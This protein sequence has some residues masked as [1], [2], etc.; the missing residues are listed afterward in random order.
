M[1]SSQ[2]LGKWQ[3]GVKSITTQ[4]TADLKRCDWCLGDDLYMDYHD[5]EWGVPLHD[6]RKLFELLILEGAQAGLSWLTI[7]RKRE[8]Y[9]KAFHNFDI[10]KSAKLTDEDVD[11]LI[12][13]SNIFRNKLKIASVI[14]NAVV[15]L[16]IQKEFGSFDKYLWGFVSGKTIKNRCKIMS[17]LPSV[18]SIAIELSKDLKERGMKF[19]GPT[20]C[21]SFMQSNGMVNDHLIEC[22]RYKELN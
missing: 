8:G 5:N 2:Y 16:E 17:E 4:E 22:F 3:I 9:K 15:V 21:Y 11:N 14:K 13:D 6:D 10:K 20:I 19:V 1:T 12:K 18:S 7:L